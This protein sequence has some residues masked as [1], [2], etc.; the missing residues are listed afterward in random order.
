MVGRGTA[1]FE[2]VWPFI[3]YRAE[4]RVNPVLGPD[5]EDNESACPCRDID[6]QSHTT[7]VRQADHVLKAIEG[8]LQV[9]GEGGHSGLGVVGV[10]VDGVLHGVARVEAHVGI[11]PDDA[12]DDQ[13]REKAGQHVEIIVGLR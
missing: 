1:H 2:V 6:V 9:L 13:R 12:E 5:A 3:A 7:Q 10:V 11:G 8:H 4:D